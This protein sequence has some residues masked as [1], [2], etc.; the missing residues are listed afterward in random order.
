MRT[1][2]NEFRLISDAIDVLDAKVI[3]F[4]VKFNRHVIPGFNKFDVANLVM[5]KLKDLLRVESFQIGQPIIEADLINAIIN[6]RGVMSYNQ[7]KLENVSGN[8]LKREYS[9][10]YEIV[11]S[12][13]EWSGKFMLSSLETYDVV[14]KSPYGINS[15]FLTPIT[16]TWYL[17]TILENQFKLA[18]T[19]YPPK[20]ENH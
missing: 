17:S 9:S 12:E 3:N 13:E 19:V 6:T 10:N 8:I 16:L 20:T 2:L 15:I 14:S 18:A 11:N 5:S 1:Y 7:L 4:K